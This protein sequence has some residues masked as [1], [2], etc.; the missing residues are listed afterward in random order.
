MI[1]PVRVLRD[2]HVASIWSFIRSLR[3][4]RSS[5]STVYALTGGLMLQ[6]L[7]GYNFSVPCGSDYI[8][9]FDIAVETGVV[10]GGVLHEALTSC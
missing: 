5:F 9:L 3:A 6:R 10:H 8:A 1:V 4:A 7:L 2:L